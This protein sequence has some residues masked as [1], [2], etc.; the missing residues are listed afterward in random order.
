[1]KHI[2]VSGPY[3]GGDCVLNTR[4]AVEA[5]SQLLEAGFAPYCPHLTLFW[6]YLTPRPYEDWLK[7][8]L[9]WVEVCD[10][11]LRLEGDS[12]GADREVAH[13]RAHG[14]PVFGSVADVRRHFAAPT[15]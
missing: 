11:L 8:D 14:I 5:A 7:L 15:P 13:A 10:G 2:F 12:P 1:M 6:H 4:A 3:T 9:A